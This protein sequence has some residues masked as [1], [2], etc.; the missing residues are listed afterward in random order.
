[1]SIVQEM[2]EKEEVTVSWIQ[3]SE[4]LVDALTKDG[5][6]STNLLKVLQ[7]AHTKKNAR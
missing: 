5:S 6:L 4:Q 7:E 3:S 2:I 1:M